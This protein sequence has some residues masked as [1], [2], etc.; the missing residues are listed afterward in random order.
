VCAAIKQ[1][2]DIFENYI[3]RKFTKGKNAWN[4][5]ITSLP[6]KILESRTLYSDFL[7]NCPMI[8]G[9]V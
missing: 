6:N 5:K 4:A 2:K 7:T 9:F 8:M 3:N 1:I